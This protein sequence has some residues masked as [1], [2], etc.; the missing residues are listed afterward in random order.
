MRKKRHTFFLVVKEFCHFMCNDEKQN[1]LSGQNHVFHIVDKVNKYKLKCHFTDCMW[2]FLH[3]VPFN[4]NCKFSNEREREREGRVFRSFCTITI[5]A[6]KPVQNNRNNIQYSGQNENNKNYAVDLFFSH[7][8]VE[9]LK[10]IRIVT[11][12]ASN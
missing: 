1:V 10:K 3:S 12:E 2:T 11:Y 7:T 5:T 9:L 4:K 8:L 6:A